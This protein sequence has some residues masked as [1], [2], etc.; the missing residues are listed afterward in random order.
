M[1]FVFDITVIY[2]KHFSHI[3]V[4]LKLVG[5]TFMY[6]RGILRAY[7]LLYKIHFFHKRDLELAS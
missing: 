3:E 2:I 7:N 6:V 5:S 1:V 4:S